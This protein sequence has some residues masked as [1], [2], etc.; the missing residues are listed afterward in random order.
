MSQLLLWS[1]LCLWLL[2][3][4]CTKVEKSSSLNGMFQLLL[5]EITR[6]NLK[7]TSKATVTGMIMF[8]KNVEV[9]SRKDTPRPSALKD[10]WLIKLK[11]CSPLIANKERDK[12]TINY[13]GKAPS[14]RKWTTMSTLRTSYSLT[15]I[16]TWFWHFE[17]EA[18]ILPFRSLTRFKTK[19]IKST[20]YS[21]TLIHWLD[22]RR[23]LLLLKRK[24]H[25]FLPWNLK[26]NRPCLAN[27]LSSRARP[28]LQTLFGRT[29]SLHHQTISSVKL[30]HTRLLPSCWRSASILFTELPEP[31]QS[32]LELSLESNVTSLETPMALVCRRTLLKIMTSLLTL[33]IAVFH[34]A[35]P[36]SV[37]AWPRWN[38]ITTKR[39][40]QPTT[41][42]KERRYAASTIASLLKCSFGSTHW[43]T[44]SLL[45]TSF[46]G[47]SA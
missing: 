38:G 14:L 12:A 10:I 37:S 27:P 18:A 1:V 16:V 35:V 7:L 47:L 9:K 19:M 42:L 4:G 3:N 11:K 28:S 36:F 46:W 23:P 2:Y 41:I 8:M 43:P 44:S 13:R 6:L 30:R 20:S 24:M 32:C 17:K 26:L 22:P 39:W 34:P 29:V 33:T 15:T 25:A 31:L 21:W 45:S 40:L 5:L